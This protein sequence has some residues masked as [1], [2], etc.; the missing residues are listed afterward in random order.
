MA[1][2]AEAYEKTA[3]QRSLWW[4]WKELNN[5]D[6][7]LS[8]NPGD[9]VVVAGE[10]PGHLSRFTTV[11]QNYNPDILVIATHLGEYR[12]PKY[13]GS[14]TQIGE[15]L[16]KSKDLALAE[17]AVVFCTIHKPKVSLE[18]VKE[19]GPLLADMYLKL[20]DLSHGSVDLQV[21][22]N[23]KGRDGF[24][25]ST[26]LITPPPETSNEPD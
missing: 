4:P 22:K 10:K 15:I 6:H 13:E 23:R 14:W 26:S 2:L 19:M 3:K 24:K 18:V 1:N 9:L 25:V 8:V 5:P 17:R 20:V 16:T 12:K 7:M 11:I 21:V